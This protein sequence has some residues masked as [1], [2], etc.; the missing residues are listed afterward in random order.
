MKTG[1][2][3]RMACLSSPLASR[4]VEGRA[5]FTPGTWLHSDSTDHEWVDPSC[6]PAPLFPRNTQGTGNCPPDM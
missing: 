1:S 6:P 5:I 3:S 4:G 2:G